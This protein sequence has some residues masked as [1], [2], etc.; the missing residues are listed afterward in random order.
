MLACSS[1]A[2]SA[3]NYSPWTSSTSL[4]S[5]GINGR[6]DKLFL[7]NSLSPMPCLHAMLLCIYLKLETESL[8][9]SP[10]LCM[11]RVE[12]FYS[13]IDGVV[14]ELVIKG[15]TEQSFLVTS[16]KSIA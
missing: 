7:S 11:T 2:S 4:S 1:D 15:Y 6:E 5:L 9:N 12:M 3:S 8:T 14:N 16:V 13:G 10:L